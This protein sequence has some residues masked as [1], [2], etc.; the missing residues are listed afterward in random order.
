MLA[1]DGDDLD[2]TLPGQR[3]EQRPRH[4]QRFLVGQPQV[5]AALDGRQRHGQPGGPDDRR[6]GEVGVARLH[7]LNQPG[8]TGQ[9]ARPWR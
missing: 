7:Q 5:Q 6:Q 4:D 8:R 9:H 1:V 2:A 3:H